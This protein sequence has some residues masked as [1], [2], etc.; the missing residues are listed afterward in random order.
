M[1]RQAATLLGEKARAEKIMPAWGEAR[2]L[3]WTAR[4]HPGSQVALSVVRF[5]SAA[6]ARSFF[7]LAVDLQRK[8]DGLSNPGCTFCPRV[9][10]SRSSALRLP[11]T[12]EAVRHDKRLQFGSGAPIPVC[13]LLARA[14]DL[15][16]E[17]SWHQ[18][19]PDT[20]WVRRIIAA[21]LKGSPKG[22]RPSPPARRSSP[23]G[24]PSGT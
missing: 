9:L 22:I 16:F 5:T 19:P 20:V 12:D 14:G 3:V 10:Q 4:K 7:G 6:S 13:V 17:V 15:V 8:R 24:T 21:L 1:V 23:T 2:S 18:A 11:G